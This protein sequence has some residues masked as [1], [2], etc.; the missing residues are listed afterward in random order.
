LNLLQTIKKEIKAKAQPTPKANQ[1]TLFKS[2]VANPEGR[3]VSIFVLVREED[4]A[5]D[6]IFQTDS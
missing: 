4:G 2:K 6:K 5:I 3:C 1:L